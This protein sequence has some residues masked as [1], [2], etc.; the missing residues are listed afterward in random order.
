M[1]FEH[2]TL[3]ICKIIVR[4]EAL[5]NEPRV[6]LWSAT[7]SSSNFSIKNLNIPEFTT[8]FVLKHVGHRRLGRTVLNNYVRQS[9]PFPNSLIAHR[10][11]SRLP[12]FSHII[13]LQSLGV[14]LSSVLQWVENVLFSLNQFQKK[15]VSL[16]VR[17]VVFESLAQLAHKEIR[18][19]LPPLLLPCLP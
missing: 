2:N 11:I 1:R 10:L 17:Q 18:Y 19:T 12:S 8:L 6:K 4:K 14:S 9:C 13:Y 3:R 15:W 5:K 7:P 16:Q